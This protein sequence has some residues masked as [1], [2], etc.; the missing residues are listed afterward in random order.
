MLN[1]KKPKKLIEVA[2]P[3]DEINE[4][5]TREKSI[6]KGHPSTLHLW[7]A[8]RPLATAR[9]ILFAQLVND[10]GGERGWYKGKT[11][12]QADAER[13]RLFDIIREL[14]KWENLNNEDVLNRAR[15]EI[16]RSWKETCELN[17]GKPGFDPDILPDFHDPF[18]GGGSIPVEAQ[19]LGLRPISTDLNPVAITINKA[20]IEIPPRFAN[21]PPVGPEVNEQ[22]SLVQEW[23]LAT[24]LA[25]DIRRYAKV[26]SDKAFQAIGHHYPKVQVHESF[27]G[28]QA[29]V[30]AWLWGRTVASP[31]PAA[32]GK[33]VPLVSTFWLCK[34]KGKEVYV[35]PVVSGTDYHF[36]LKRGIP[37]NPDEVQAGTKASRGANFTCLL[38][39]SPIP[40]DYVKSEGKAGRL[41]WKLIGIVA[42]GKKGRLYAEPTNEHESIGL[43]AQPSWRPEF[44]LSTHPQYMSVTNYG[45]STVADL[46]MDRQTLALNTF[47]EKLTEM[48]ELIQS[49]AMRAGMSG[50]NK[51]LKDGGAGATAYADAVCIYLGLSISRLAN[52]QSTNTIWDTTRESVQQVFAR[53]ALPMIWDTAEGNPF[54][55]SSGNFLG[56]VDYLAA[57]LSTLPAEGKEGIAFQK[58]A[59]TADFRNQ[60]VSTDP[61]YYDNVPYADLS[62][63]FY[64]WLR[65]S[66]REYLPDTYS[67]MLVPK[68]EELVA[69]HKRHAGKDKAEAFFM[70]GMTDVMHQIA[71]N[72]HPA[73]PVTIYYAFRSSE[74]T[75]A[76]TSST[77]WETF[78]ESVLRAGF[79]ISGTWPVR[80]ELTGNLKKNWNALA[81]SIVLV[82][83]K[84][85]E[86]A[87]QIP[88]RDFQR[89]LREEL[90]EALEAMT[91]G[92][93]GF[94]T[95]KPVDLAQS[96]IGPGMA[97]FSRYKAVLNQD[98]SKMG[99]HEALKMI[100]RIKDEILGISG[101]DD[102]DTAFCVDWF[103]DLGWS[104]GRFGDAD[105]LA[106][107]KGT[108]V[109][110][111]ESA[112]V[113][114]TGSG[115]A[116]LLKW[117]EYPQDWDPIKDERTPIWEACHHM[118]RALQNS[119]E[120]AAGNLLSR[121]PE[122][123]EK[124]RQLSY[125]LYSVCEKK[126]WAEEARS[127]NALIASW[128]EIL[129]ASHEVGHKGEQQGLDF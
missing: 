98:G 30:L 16:L 69:D 90:P 59:Q 65:R 39:G 50:S 127:Y 48:H 102:S 46:F 15:Q 114:W 2:L 68:T 31:N 35:K 17:K 96:S 120:S 86:T 7:W 94:A 40:A 95:V 83:T 32:N 93:T 56:Q 100:N 109:P 25:E 105:I 129:L 1:I 47:A 79:S 41:G 115:K 73:F 72:A 10:P 21:L 67:T 54:S 106:Q 53:H 29:T 124:I 37:E 128:N 33:H 119:G 118:I 24:G 113:L 51:S 36:E 28:G 27:G 81:S 78:L 77:G 74:T 92:N 126:N 9:A 58:D 108:S 70:D 5:A 104:E 55:E 8:R 22:K 43:A 60:V 18:A 42:E 122:K 44:P 38:T 6:R 116:K 107:A 88:R 110:G 20:M 26:L 75:E 11:K 121:M 19:R 123:S 64:V 112:G 23:K 14:V 71:D 61:P 103:S 34:K 125:H 117:Q 99:V 97:I 63:F 3:L 76:G 13:E 12:A 111:L 89:I 101:A 4:Q 80:T 57:A 52:R 85:E 49:D 84:R 82:C 45:P 66:L 62:D 91:G 87:E